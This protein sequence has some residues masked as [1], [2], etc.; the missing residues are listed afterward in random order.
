M[1]GYKMQ[2]DAYEEVLQKKK[3]LDPA[4][5]EDLKSKIKAFKALEGTTDKDRANIFNTGAFN[6]ITKAYFKKAMEGTE[7]DQDTITA[8]LD[9]YKYLLDTVSAAEIMQ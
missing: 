8:V 5:T 2:A 3:D 4:V 1:D 9:E 7:I 6:D